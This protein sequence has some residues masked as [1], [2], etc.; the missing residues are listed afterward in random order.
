M[1]KEQK[2]LER[3]PTMKQAHDVETVSSKKLGNLLS[4]HG[5]N[6]YKVGLIGAYH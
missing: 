2:V 5:G 6:L 4:L 1:T 3:S